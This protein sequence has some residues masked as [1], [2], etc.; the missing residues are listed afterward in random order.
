MRLRRLE[1]VVI[2]L[3]LAFVCFLGGYF[4]GLRSAVSIVTVSA[5]DSTVHQ[6]NRADDR[7]SA[8]TA[9]QSQ[10]TTTTDSHETSG[11]TQAPP[12]G[13]T[14]Q[15]VLPVVSTRDSEGRI[16]INLASR[17]ELM[18]LPGIGSVLA[19]RI[20][21]YRTSNGAYARI[22][23]LRNVSGIGERRFEAIQDKVTVG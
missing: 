15:S 19:E 11:E 17:T 3:T 2:G 20:V 13:E 23:D 21:E 16:N 14:A 12:A 7:Q 18:D 1:L 8:G 6:Q 5:Q 22:E 9:A 10:E 4:T